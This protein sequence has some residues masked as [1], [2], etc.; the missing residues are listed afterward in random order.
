VD[1]LLRA[2]RDAVLTAC[3]FWARGGESQAPAA[4]PQAV[5]TLLVAAGVPNLLAGLAGVVQAQLA[6][7]GPGL[8]PEQGTRAREV[9][10]R[11][12]A[13]EQLR[14]LA[15]E[16]ISSSPPDMLAE[17]YQWLTSGEVAEARREAAEYRPSL[18]FEEFL[19][20]L[21]AL[22]PA[23][24]RVLLM[25]RLA[26][27]QGAGPFYLTLAE[28]ARGAASSAAR[29]LDPSLPLFRSLPPDQAAA[30]LEVHEQQTVLLFL[31]RYAPISDERIAAMAER[32]ESP[33]GR[34]YVDALLRA[35]R[36]AVL[37]AAERAADELRRTAAHSSP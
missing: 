3:A 23:R 30:A 35:A 33:S 7:L 18:P 5:D 27:A 16:T 4:P 13:A 10:A 17:V 2:A 32:Y 11:H 37:T 25:V 6:R 24:Q 31:H 28:A 36:D 1:A 26:Q 12:F 34:W 21:A 15:G 9:V 20:A 19:A 29:A 14:E 22:P 8:T